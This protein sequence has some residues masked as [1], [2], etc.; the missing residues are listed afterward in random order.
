MDFTI[1]KVSE[2][3]PY[4]FRQEV[5]S[6]DNNASYDFVSVAEPFKVFTINKLNGSFYWQNDNKIIETESDFV[7]DCQ[8]MGLI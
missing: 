2:L 1:D 4:N 5:I 3:I 6:D 8:R 7:R